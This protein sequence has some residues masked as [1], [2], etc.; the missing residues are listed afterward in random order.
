MDSMLVLSGINL[1]KSLKPERCPFE[2]Y[3]RTIRQR[4]RRD[5]SSLGDAVC[6]LMS[7]DCM[8]ATVALGKGGLEGSM[9]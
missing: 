1:G 6:R 2:R 9:S 3:A 4:F 8:H 7:I 5:G